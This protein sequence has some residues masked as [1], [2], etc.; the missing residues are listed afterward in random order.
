MSF[1]NSDIVQE[2][3]QTIYDSYVDLQK[4][5]KAIGEMPI[6]TAINHINKTKQLIEKQRLFYTRLQLCSSEDNEARDMKQRIDL[7]SDMFG[8]DTIVES[9]D[10]MTKYLDNVLRSL[11]KA[12]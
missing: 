8:Y 10:S 12:V 6:P 1:F 7:I 4:C 5:G 9:L 2:Q 3:L 11:D